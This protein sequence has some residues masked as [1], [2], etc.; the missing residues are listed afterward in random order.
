MHAY[1][2]NLAR[3]VRAARTNATISQHTLAE[4]VDCDDRTILNIERGRGNPQ[5]LTLCAIF[6]CLNIPSS[7]VFETD[8][9]D[10]SLEKQKLMLMIKNCS[11]EDAAALLP[12]MEPLLAAI[13]RD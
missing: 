10:L 2:K 4:L 6:R 3:V 5:F 9:S 11:D 1:V 8:D 13:R 7:Q 12:V